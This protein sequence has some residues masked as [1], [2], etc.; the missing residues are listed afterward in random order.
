MP[1]EI[2][3]SPR[4]RK[5]GDA[6]FRIRK[7]GRRCRCTK[8][9]VIILLGSANRRFSRRTFGRDRN[10]NSTC[11]PETQNDRTTWNE[12][13]PHP[14]GLPLP[15]NYSSFTFFNADYLSIRKINMYIN[16]RRRDDCLVPL[17]NG[18]A[19]NV[20]FQGNSGPKCQTMPCRMLLLPR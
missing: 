19:E 2:R 1:D 20:L 17:R 9:N 4:N 5:C 10:R 14:A 12:G 15:I 8:L 11:M 7:S 16:G 3:H 13:N 18:V 6:A